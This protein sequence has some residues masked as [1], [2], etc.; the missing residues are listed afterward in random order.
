MLELVQQYAASLPEF[1]FEEREA[2]LENQYFS[3]EKYLAETKLGSYK[4]DEILI[5]EILA[6]KV[7]VSKKIH[8]YYNKND[9]K[10]IGDEYISS[11]FGHLMICHYMSLFL[12]LDDYK[13]VNTLLKILD[14][15]LMSPLLN[16]PLEL[17]IICEKFLKNVI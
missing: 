5:F 17:R 10:S 1:I 11:K 2:E 8:K 12:F 14:N 4:A 16:I 7:E 6:K 9:F 13:Y 3:V 15:I